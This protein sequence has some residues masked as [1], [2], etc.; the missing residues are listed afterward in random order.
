VSTSLQP[1]APAGAEQAAAEVVAGLRLREDVPRDRPRTVGVMIASADGRASVRGRSGGLGHPAD[2]ALL[3]SLRAAV[4]AVV[5][6]TR[7]LAAEKYANLLDPDQR[8]D[9]VAAGRSALPQ[10]VTISRTAATPVAAPLFAEPDATIRVY[11]EVDAPAPSRGATVHVHALAPLTLSAV[12]AHLRTAVGLEVVSCEGG[13]TLL[14]ALVAEGLLDDLLL[15]LAPLL[16]AGTEPT[17]LAGP[18]L[19]PA[20]RLA[21]DALHRAD[22]HVFCHYRVQR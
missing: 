11:G 17:A 18:E 7:T 10:V 2:R 8:A 15:T 21:L 12:L 13:P 16:V 20:T 4:D 19:H 1:L 5:V 3:R 14:R 6:G 9:R 22:D